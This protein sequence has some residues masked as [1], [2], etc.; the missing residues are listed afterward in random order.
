MHQNPWTIL[1]C[2]PGVW[3][4]CCRTVFK[5]LKSRY[6]VWPSVVM[7]NNRYIG[8]L[9]A[10]SYV[11]SAQPWLYRKETVCF[12]HSAI[13]RCTRSTPF[14]HPEVDSHPRWNNRKKFTREVPIKSSSME[15][16]WWAIFL[17]IASICAHIMART[18]GLVISHLWKFYADERLF[19]SHRN[20]GLIGLEE[21]NINDT[22]LAARNSVVS[23][24]LFFSSLG[25]E[26]Q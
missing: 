3:R 14:S 8:Y 26:S 6:R 13:H 10:L 2:R 15:A 11:W 17:P 16:I 22:G 9:L 4:H 12:E 25:V 1:H 18:A 19:E 24:L 23:M 5:R 21:G 7:G 20:S